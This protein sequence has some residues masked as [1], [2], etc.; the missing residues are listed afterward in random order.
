M[1]AYEVIESIDAEIAA[2]QK[3]LG[4]GSW[5]NYDADIANLEDLKNKRQLF[6]AMI[7]NATNEARRKVKN[8]D[9]RPK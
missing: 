2:I 5:E 7:N 6:C 9:R 4:N 8:N 3:R 1:N